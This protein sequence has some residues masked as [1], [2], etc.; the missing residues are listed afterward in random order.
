MRHEQPLLFDTAE[1][2]G[3]QENLAGTDR[4]IE[5]TLA[6][7]LENALDSLEAPASVKP[8]LGYQ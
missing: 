4:S 7:T 6:Q 2:P 1:D 3:Q 8:R 5:T